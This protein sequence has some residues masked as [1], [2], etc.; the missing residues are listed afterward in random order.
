MRADAL[1]STRV[2]AETLCEALPNLTPKDA[3]WRITLV[4][5]AYLYA[6]SDTHRLNL[7]APGICNPDD[8]EEVLSAIMELCDRQH[9]READDGL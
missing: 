9:A 8:Y 7:P 5:G 3:Y 6:F 1:E 2:F 4:V